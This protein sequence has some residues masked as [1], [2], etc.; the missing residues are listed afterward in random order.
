MPNRE[1]FK[2]TVL[3]SN[4][5]LTEITVPPPAAG[6]KAFYLKHRERDGFD[7]PLAEAAAVLTMSAGVV[8]A[9]RI[10]LGHAAPIPWRVKRAEEALVGKKLDAASALEAGKAAMRGAKPMRDNAYKIDLFPVVVQRTLLA[11][12]GLAQA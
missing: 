8:K 7:W 1:L 2:E 10:V 11:A 3:E 9:A 5:I 6:T 4:E 12:A